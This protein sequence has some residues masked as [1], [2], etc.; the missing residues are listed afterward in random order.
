MSILGLILLIIVLNQV[1]KI[2]YSLFQANT[3]RKGDRSKQGRSTV[4]IKSHQPP[5][6]I[7][8][9]NEGEYVDFEEIKQDPAENPPKED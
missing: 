3:K 7:F 2:I 1:I 6:K 8:S 9:P 5:K 4:D